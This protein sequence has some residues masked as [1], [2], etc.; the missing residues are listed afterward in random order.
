MIHKCN[1]TN[2]IMHVFVYYNS[3][4]FIL[5]YLLKKSSHIKL[6]C[7]SVLLHFDTSG[8]PRFESAAQ[9]INILSIVQRLLSFL[10]LTMLTGRVFRR[11]L[12]DFSFPLA[13]ST[14][15]L[16]RDIFLECI[17]SNPVNC[18]LPFVDAG[19]KIIRKIEASI[20]HYMVSLF[21]EVNQP[22][23]FCYYLVTSTTTPDF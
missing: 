23:I 3:C 12:N 8:F 14:W 13:L 10:R 20:S 7:G 1:T 2:I 11:I 16:T 19:G 15:I 21:K 5:I 18:F 6:I 17:T 9:T 22:R 4:I